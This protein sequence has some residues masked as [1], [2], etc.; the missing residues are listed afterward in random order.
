MPVVRCQQG[1]H[2]VGNGIALSKNAHWTFDQGLWA[3]S[4]DHRVV[5][6]S[7]EFTEPAD[8]P[9]LLLA[10]YH[11]ALLRLPADHALWPSLPQLAWHRRHKL[12][13]R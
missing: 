13:G 1:A 6:A 2:A 12:N 9:D 5:V 7:G 11:G 3:I 8:T 10:Y 4:D